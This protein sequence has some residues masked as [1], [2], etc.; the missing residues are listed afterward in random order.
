MGGTERLPSTQGR[1]AE[2]RQ[3]AGPSVSGPRGGEALRSA[4]SSYVGTDPQS[5]LALQRT[6]GN[7][8]VRRLLDESAVQPTSGK[9]VIRRLMVKSS[10][11]DATMGKSDKGVLGVGKSTYAVIKSLI[12][13][14]EKA[15]A[16]DA[17]PQKLADILADLDKQVTKW[18][19]EHRK[20][21][22]D[23]DLDRRGV[24]EELSDD[25]MHERAS[26]SKTQAHDEY[27][28]GIAKGTHSEGGA[29]GFKAL[30]GGKPM[31]AVDNWEKKLG[32]AQRGRQFLSATPDVKSDPEIRLEQRRQ[33]A[34]DRNVTNAEQAAFGV[35]TQEAGDFEYINPAA[36]GHTG[37][38]DAETD[39]LAAAKQ[40][41]LE[42]ATKNKREP[43]YGA[44]PNQT[45]REEGALHMAMVVS[46]LQ[47]LEPYQGVSYRGES[48]TE[49]VFKARAKVGK[50]FNFPS[51]TSS[52]KKTSIALS[53]ADKNNGAD[54]DIAVLWVFTN[55]GKDIE[56]F[57]VME[58][59]EG[60]VLIEPSEKFVVDRV[61]D[62]DAGGSNPSEGKP[63]YDALKTERPKWKHR[64]KCYVVHV[65]GAP[66]GPAPQPPAPLPP[67]P[68]VPAPSKQSKQRAKVAEK[69]EGRSRAKLKSKAPTKP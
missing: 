41:K 59:S 21:L 60:E 27:L 45:L 24:M 26:L 11:L 55:A 6:A 23:R 15:K 68:A 33:L 36:S 7:R 39:R 29:G 12:G 67:L 58:T 32:E 3:V 2:K 14:Y 9:D 65:M 30:S 48:L 20:E 1:A 16:G 51:V 10:D 47:K 35:F 62:F 31:G 53:F 44:L 42:L 63:L 50:P 22:G 4:G 52:S 19:N 18:L 43:G 66:T 49:D 38:R 40:A 37:E 28:G 13:K 61:V 64:R 17:P 54:K 46:G 56:P 34:Q 8:V 57:S 25:L 5:I 69:G